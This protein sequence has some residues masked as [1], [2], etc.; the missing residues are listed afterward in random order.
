[1][2]TVPASELTAR[3]ARLQRL[4]EEAGISLGLIRQPADLFYYTGVVVEGFLAA[5]AAGRPLLLVR[6][7]RERPTVGET[8]WEMVFYSDLKEL[9]GLV[10]E[11]CPNFSSIGLE[12]DVLPAALYVRLKDHLFAGAVCQDI[13]LLVRRQRMVKSPYELEQIKRAA[14]VLDR[15]LAE[16]PT[17]IRPG[18]TELELAAAIEYR[19]RLLEHQGLVRVRRWDMEMFY[20]HV[21]SGASG[22]APAYTD[23]P[24]GGVGFSPAFPQGASKKELKPGEPI[25]ID[26]AA[27]INGYVADM[28]RLYAIRDLP[29]AAWR[30]FD[31][32]LELF[33]IF[34]SEARAGVLPGDLY[35]RLVGE[36]QRR[37]MGGYFMGRGADRVSFLGH[38][39]GLELDELPL[40]TAR[41]PF[42]LEADMVLAFE[43]KLFLP[44]VG[45]VGLEDTGRIT[46]DGVEWLTQA[47][48][49]VVIIAA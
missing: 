33:Q 38:G 3:L 28:T 5:P 44:E 15:A 36:V 18:V 11:I 46:A 41:S 31:L 27:C 24:S 43:P 10:G 48:R 26:L 20:G 16:A 9:S 37:G 6:R 17:L 39:V 23:T 22:L 49:P 19:L 29:V 21:L 47:P 2:E 14:A 32:I 12:M 1:M 35:Q 13:S 30:A 40:L 45:M 8:P 4:L 34:E 42:P 7:P 25:S